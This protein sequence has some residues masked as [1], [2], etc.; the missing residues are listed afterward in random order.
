MEVNAWTAGSN[1]P[2]E[3]CGVIPKINGGHTSGKSGWGILGKKVRATPHWSLGTALATVEL[4][5]RQGAMVRELELWDCTWEPKRVRRGEEMSIPPSYEWK[6]TTCDW[7][8]HGI[9]PELSYLWIE[10]A[11]NPLREEEGWEEI[12]EGKVESVGTV[13]LSEQGWHLF[14]TT[15]AAGQNPMWLLGDA[16]ARARQAG[17]KFANQGWDTVSSR[18]VMGGWK[19]FK[20]PG[21]RTKT[22]VP[23]FVADWF[24]G[25]DHVTEV[26]DTMERIHVDCAWLAEE[27]YRTSLKFG[28]FHGDRARE[29]L[30]I[31]DI[32]RN[33]R[34]KVAPETREAII[35]REVAATP[36]YVDD[37]FKLFEE[38]EGECAM[39]R[40][41]TFLEERPLGI[42]PPREVPGGIEVSLPAAS[43]GWHPVADWVGVELAENMVYLVTKV[44]W[45]ADENGEWNPDPR[46]HVRAEGRLYVSEDG[47][48]EFGVRLASGREPLSMFEGAWQLVWQAGFEFAD[49][50]FDDVTAD[51]RVA[52]VGNFELPSENVR[53]RM[54][55]FL[56]E[57][58]GGLELARQVVADLANLTYEDA[59]VYREYYRAFLEMGPFSGEQKYEVLRILRVVFGTRSRAPVVGCEVLWGVVR[60]EINQGMAYVDD[61][62]R[63]YE[64]TEVETEFKA[65]L[66]EQ[67]MVGN[68]GDP[69]GAGSREGRRTSQDEARS[70]KGEILGPRGKRVNWNSPGGMR[71][72]VILL[73]NLEIAAVEAEPIAEIVWDQP[74]GR[75]PQANF[76][77]EGNNQD[78]VN[79]TTS[80]AGAEKKLIQDTVMEELAGTSAGQQEAE[81]GEQEKVYGK[82]IPMGF[83]NTV[84][85]AQRRMLAVAGDMFPEKCEPYI[86]DNPV[87][88]TRYKDET[89]VQPG[90]RKFVWDHL[91]D[92]KDLLQRFL[93]YN[94]TASGP[95]SIL[96]VPEVIILGFRCGACGRRPD[97]AK[98]DKISQWPTPLRTTTE[99]RAFLGVVG[100]WRIV[101]KGFAKIAEPIRAM[102]REG[103]TMDWTEDREAAAQTLKDI[104]SSDQVTLAAPCFNDEVG[105]P[106]ILETD[107]GPLAVGG[108]LIQ[109]SEEGKER[110]IRFESRTLNSAERRYS[111]FKKEVL[112]ILHCL[113][114][115]QAY[116]FGRR[117][118][119]RIDP[120]N[121]V[122]A[123]KNYK[124]VDPTVGRWIGFTWQF[125]YK[126]ERIAGLRNRADG[127]SRVCTTPEGV[128]DAKPIDSFLEYEG[129]TLVADNEMADPAIT[130][131][132]LLIQ[133]L[134]KGAPAIVAE[135]REGPVTTVR[136]KEEKDS[137]GAEVGAREE[138][139]A[140][141]GEG[142]RDAVMTLAETWIRKEC[143][144]LVNQTREEQGTDQREQE[145]FLI[146]IEQ[147]ATREDVVSSLLDLL[148][149]RQERLTVHG[150]VLRRLL[151]VLSNSDRTLPIIPVQ[152]GTSTRVYPALWDSGSQGDFIYPRVVKEARLPTTGSL[153]PIP[154]TLGD[155][156]SQRFF[157][158]TVTDLPFFLTLEPTDRPPTSRRHRSSA[159]F[160]VMETRY[161]FILGTPWSYRFRSP[162]ADWA[163]NTLVLRTKC[164]QT[165]RIPFIGTTATPRPDP[166]PPEPSVPTPSPTITVTSPRQFAHFIRQEDV[167]FFTV[168][169]TDL[170]HYDPPCPDA[171]LISL[172]PDPPSIS[173][174][175]ISTSL[176]PPSVESNPSSCADAEELARYTADLE[177]AV[178]D[179]VREYHNVFPS[180]F[181][182]A[183][184]PPMR[185]VEHS[186]QL[187]PDYRVHHQAPYRLS[188]PEATE[189]ERQLEELLRLGFIKSNNSPWVASVLFARKADETLR[190][191]IDYHGLNRYTVKNNYPTPRSD[192]LFDRLAG[193]RFFTKNDPRSVYHQI[194]VAA[195]DQLKIAFR[196]HFGHYEFTVMP[197]GLTN[198]PATFQ[199]LMNDI[200]RDILGQYVLVYLDDILIYSRTLEEHLR[201][202]HDILD[203]LRRHGFYAKLSKCRFAQHKVDFLG[204][205]VSDQG[206]HMDDAKITA[207]AEWP[208]PTSAKQLRSF[209]SLASYYSSFIQGYARY[210]YVLTSTFLQ[211]NQLWVCTP[212]HEDAFRALKKGVRCAPV[213]H[214][215]D[216]D[217]PFVLTTDASDF[218]VGAVLS[219]ISPSSPDSS[220]PRIPRFPPPTPTTASRLTPTRPATDEPS[221]DYSP[222]IA[223]DGTVES[224][225]GDCRIAFYSRQLLPVEI[226]YTADEREVLTVVYA[227]RHWRHYLLGAPFT[228]RT[229]NSVVQAFLTKP[230]LTPRQA[231][232]WCDLSKFRFTTEHMK[233]E[234]N[235][236]TNALSRRPDHNLKQIRLAAIS[237]TTVHHSVIDEFRTRCRHCPDYRDI[238]ATLRISIRP[239]DRYKSAFKTRYGHFEWVVMPFGLTNAP[240]T[241]QAAMTN[242]FRPMLDQSVL[243]YLDDIL[244]YRR[245]LEDHLE[246]LRR[247]LETLR[248]TKYKANRDKCE[249][250]RQELEYLGHFVTPE[251]ISPLSGKIQAIQEWSE[252]RNVTDV[253]SFLGLVGYYQRFIK[254]YSKIAAHLTKLQ[255]EDWP[256]D[257]GEDAWESF[258][259]LKAALLSVE[260]LR[261]YDPLL[262]TSVTTDASGYGIGVVLEQHDGVDW[263]PVEY[264]SK[265]VSVVHSIDDAHKELLAFVHALKRWRQFLL[266][267]SQF[268]WVTN[269]N[270]LVFYK[271]QDT[272]NS[273]IARWISS[274][275]SNPFPITFRGS[276]NRFADALSRR[277]DHCTAVYSTF[278]ING[279]LQDSFTRGY[280]ADPE[281]RVKYANCS[282]PNPAPS[283]YRIQEGYLLVHTRGKDPLCVPSDSHLRTRILGEFHDAP[284]TGHFGV[285][286]TIGRLRERF[287]W[288]DVLGDVTR[289][290]E[291][292]E[293]CRCCKSRN[294]LPYGELRPLPVP[295]R[296][297]E[298]IAMDITGPFPKHKTGVDGILTVVERLTKFIMFLPCRYHAKAPELAEVLYADWIRT[299]GYPK[300]IVC[301]SDT[302][303]MS[304]F[305]LALI[306][307]WGSS[308]KPSLA[309]HPQT[310]GRT[311]RAHQ[312]AQVLLRTLIR[313]D[314]KDWVERLSDVE[315]AYNLS[316]HPTIGMSPFEFEHG[317]SGTSLL[318]TIIPRAAE[319]DNHLLFLRRMQELLV[320]ARDQ[321]AKT[322][323]RMSQQANRQR[324]P[325]PFRAGDLLWVSAAEFSLEQDIS[326]KLL[327]KWMGPWPIVAPAGDAPEGLSFIIQVPAH[328]PVYPVFHCSKLAF[329][330]PAEHDDFPGGRSQDPPSMDGFQEVSDII[331]QR[332]YGNRPTE[333]LVH[334]A[335]C[336][337]KADRWL[338][339][340]E[341]QATASDVLA[342]YERKMQGKPVCTMFNKVDL[343]FGYH[344]IAMA[345]EDVHKT[346]FKTR[347]GSYEYL[348]MPFGL[349]NA[350]GTFQIEMHRIFWP[351][352]EKFMVV[353]MDDILVFSRTAREHV[354]HLAL[355][356]QALHD[357][358]YKI[359]REKSSFG[360]PSLIYLGHVISGDGS[361]PKAAKIAAIQD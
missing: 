113:K 30:I 62:Y 343:K 325:C 285:N 178:R 67:M 331:S 225:S 240:T 19:E 195:A 34:Q 216:F 32:E 254:G 194:R 252:L 303:F 47:W 122:G 311:E 261:I 83:T 208:V 120:T 125:D 87:K 36:C 164:G 361:T 57:K 266:G 224:R 45:R 85:E 282:S 3:M 186:I 339:R 93:V 131:G 193:N 205:Y 294:Y 292:C 245:T 297:R 37:M 152:L 7:R 327:L 90:V 291:S 345:E 313:P 97:P 307:R 342:R 100:F 88:G 304:D 20:P 212:L 73:N 199:R 203:R 249:F 301:D 151:T 10:R 121:V 54:L 102:I 281:F 230:K 106:F 170:L 317:S 15:L 137:W 352:L 248:P 260:A 284:A 136:R 334:F 299:K 101:I 141:V 143:Q 188:I 347:Y 89:E 41:R 179:L 105:R 232:W 22:W 312:T 210:S 200:F 126:V 356:L 14:Y 9:V 61:L 189:L 300:E 340:A 142:G 103:G 86:D 262:P 79:I 72:A 91:Q 308:L 274:T 226:N 24:G 238:H 149:A 12:A 289:Y 360:V 198:A 278:E 265:K 323:Q 241:F 231:R 256:F 246:H 148:Q 302:R 320:K 75:G 11:W 306:K 354:E 108:V 114:T 310:D 293:V 63:L 190:L 140:M 348:V 338:I 258:L 174:A 29:V 129:G 201:H 124:P 215:P 324:L 321:M 220:H 160:D 257:L 233:G 26:A 277:P 162:E 55:P 76:I 207:I 332:R 330:T 18:V 191:C 275:N 222:T 21:T 185:D 66:I 123:L 239:N 144:Y 150:V 236:V 92:I 267:R 13:V 187:V 42:G 269:N 104:L 5:L 181:S 197:F 333:Y 355:V 167:T 71:R 138:L 247:V 357:N 161:D 98:T 172:E 155:D 283:H 286:H 49:P 8:G 117:F 17:E 328:L 280:Q 234:T 268:R 218:A 351:Y 183:G 176:L 33:D 209:F 25:F 40:R 177:P 309:R 165:Y 134:E 213:L 135:L 116:L 263:H 315:L 128:E 273:T 359:N 180:S 329:Y 219:L 319:S 147:L 56:L 81:A 109:R 322:Q 112:A 204:H 2:T 272:G 237:I 146:H 171:E 80:Q 227:T 74:R 95:K 243:V 50:G 107:R 168:N 341:L 130:T 229:D 82:V 59:M 60:Q 344:Q 23:E 157:D 156:K 182:Y 259:D 31:L 70:L 110:P 353:Y 84:A 316:I 139:M 145:F 290:C 65:R 196:S 244:V 38:T 46:G 250:V 111:Q 39:V 251:G 192:E 288:P 53:V 298:V 27:F 314:Q 206:L 358:Q 51:L 255:C 132:Q 6:G 326:C 279:D 68:E 221:I 305:W 202:L 295:L 4:C 242:E 99:V 166:P 235:R 58:W 336:T 115:F 16:E 350:P 43:E 270:P 133:T 217:R 211:K 64:P 48:K 69:Q 119:L 349:C 214:L 154:V 52:M 96:A 276:L 223:E 173:M 94:I 35:R 153:T 158:Q 346:T 228:V 78:R 163:T 28:P 175:S 318:D 253:R 118:I 296:R 77:L 159:H 127:L 271:T 335:Y 337:H 1:G 264:F 169:V 44:E 287:W 184:I